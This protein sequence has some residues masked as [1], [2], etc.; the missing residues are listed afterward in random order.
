M[1]N[2]RADSFAR[3]LSAPPRP[4][5]LVVEAPPPAKTSWLIA[6]ASVA[7]FSRRI[8]AESAATNEIRVDATVNNRARVRRQRQWQRQRRGNGERVKKL[9]KKIVE[10]SRDKGG[11][12]VGRATTIWRV[13]SMKI[14]PKSN[15]TRRLS[16]YTGLSVDR[17]RIIEKPDER[18]APQAVTK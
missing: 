15:E 8:R 1:H 4:R 10:N 17:F 3:S 7:T 14:D 11:G 2:R 12:E 13:T 6:A 9:L 18:A 5:F 16:T